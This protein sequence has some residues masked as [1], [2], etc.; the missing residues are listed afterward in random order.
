MSKHSSSAIHLTSDK[1]PKKYF[2]NLK[3]DKRLPYPIP[4]KNCCNQIQYPLDAKSDS[5]VYFN[6]YINYE[7]KC[8]EIRDECSIQALYYHGSFGKGSL[9]SNAP[10]YEVV[11]EIKNRQRS[12]NKFICEQQQ[13]LNRAFPKRPDIGSIIDDL[14][15]KTPSPSPSRSSSPV[16]SSSSSNYIRQIPIQRVD[17][18]K[19]R[20]TR[21][22]LR[23][24]LEETF[25][26]AYCLGCLTVTDPRTKSKLNLTQ[27][28]K[29]FSSIH[30]NNGDMVEFAGYYAA[31]HY[32]RS[33]GWVV[34][35][36]TKFGCDF[37][38]YKDGPAYYHA[39]FSVIVFT[40]RTDQSIGDKYPSRDWQF[41]VGLNRLSEAVRKQVVQCFVIVPQQLTDVQLSD[42]RVITT[43]EIRTTLLRRF[44]ASQE[45]TI[46]QDCDI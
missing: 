6:C 15:R 10:I 45:I 19:S 46:S 2:L 25:F 23:L 11:D 12:S 44:K 21:E 16:A 20:E 33:K 40:L 34:K 42:P 4:L 27:I 30:S 13:S 29:T 5:V 18:E 8:C 39:L 17:L 28:W 7:E 43:F 38:L 26:L 37:N 14:Y 24:S 41:H 9:S 1:K 35:S 36:G 31:Y 32:F 22:T 3:D